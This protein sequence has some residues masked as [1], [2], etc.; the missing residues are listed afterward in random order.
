MTPH[1][2]PSRR[3]PVPWATSATASCSS[4]APS[5]RC[6]R[7][8]T[9]SMCGR[10]ST[11]TADLEVRAITPLYF[12]ATKLEA[13][14]GRG[15]GDYQASHDLED[16]LSVLAGLDSLRAEV[17]T[18]TSVAGGAVRRCLCGFVL[19]TVAGLQSWPGRRDSS[20]PSPVTSRGTQPGKLGLTKFWSGS[21]ASERDGPVGPRTR[22]STLPKHSSSGE[23][24]SGRGRVPASCGCQGS[25]TTA[26]SDQHI[27]T[28]S[29]EP[30][31]Q[32][33]LRHRVVATNLVVVPSG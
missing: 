33:R 15:R 27:S 8:R 3:S 12:V 6:T 23:R 13:F 25:A 22:P 16:V 14:A 24:A 31:G 18:D 5:P 7:S 20:T 30:M 11:W 21:A 4:A 26:A 32:G 2:P 17:R 1:G 19:P 29:E 10:P 9:A 28:R